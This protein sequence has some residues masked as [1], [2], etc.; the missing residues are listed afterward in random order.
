M[1]DTREDG[2]MIMLLLRIE[3]MSPDASWQKAEKFG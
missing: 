3:K 1:Q 2:S